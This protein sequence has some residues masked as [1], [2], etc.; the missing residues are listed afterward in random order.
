MVR[1]GDK[2]PQFSLPDETGGNASLGEYRGRWVVLYFY[3]RDNTSGCTLEALDFTRALGDFEK[4]GAAVLGVSPDSVETH[5]KFK[6]KRGLS[7]RLLSDPDHKALAKYGA[8]GT[9]KLYG[10]EVTGV[11]RSTVLIDPEGRIAHVWP[12]VKVKDHVDAVK[13]KLAEL[14]R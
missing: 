2:A 1:V 9:K 13:K 4:L 11:I 12:R 7:V 3:P 8:W 14:T 10:R 5:L 6:E